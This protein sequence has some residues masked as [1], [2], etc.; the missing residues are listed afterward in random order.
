VP[1]VN[2]PSAPDEFDIFIS[3]AH[4]DDVGDIVAGLRDQ[5]E[6]DFQRLLQRRIEI[7]RDRSDIRDFEDWKVRCYRALRASCFFIVLLSPAYLTSD[8]CRWEWEEWCRHELE[9]GLVGQGAAPLWFVKL[10]DLDAPE[11]AALLRRWKGDLLQRFHIQCHKWRHDD[12]GNFLDAAAR[13]ELQQLT[14]HVAQRLRLLTLDRARRGNLP[15]PN[16]NFVGRE[17]ELASL[18]AALLDA[19]EQSPA[20]IHG[21][22][23]NGG[24]W[25]H[26]LATTRLGENELHGA[27]RDRSFLAIDELPPDDALALISHQPDGR[28]HCESERDAAR[29]ILRLLGSFTLAVES[30]AVYLGQFAND[31]T[32][33]AFLARLEKEGLEGADA[34]VTFDEPD[35]CPLTSVSYF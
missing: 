5:L 11:D 2:K 22:G 18:R 28:F 6:A 33:T 19:P 26:G 29:E 14:E 24:D 15:W 32:C 10:E 7:F 3:Y 17:P 9:H 31:V 34:A 8:A 21:V 30:A 1:L 25:L 4:R 12:H 16:A 23:G 35:V 20:G 27:H 13:S